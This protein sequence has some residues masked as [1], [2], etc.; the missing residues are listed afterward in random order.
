MMSD[1]PLQ[2]LY[3]LGLAV[4]ATLDLDHEAEAFM[5]W[6]AEAVRPALAALFVT[7][8]ARQTL[9]L[10]GVHG[11]DLPADPHLPL[12]MD[13]WRWLAEQGAPIPPEGDPARYAVPILVEQQLFGILCLVSR[14]RAGRLTREQRLVSTAANYL[15]PVLRNIWRYQTVEDL[16]EERTAS[17][18]ESEARYRRLAGRLE[19]L[20]EMDR[21]IIE[22][23]SPGEIARAALSRVRR[24]L[25]CQRA[26]VLL[27]DFEADE[28]MVLATH[29]NGETSVGTGVRLPLAAFDIGEKLKEGGVHVM[30]DTFALSELPPVVERLREEGIR[31][32]VSVPLIVEGRLIGALYLGT[33]RP[34]TFTDEQIEIAREVANSLAIAIQQARL[35]EEV[36][37]HARE[38]EQRVAERTR[39]LAASEAR[40]RQIVE[41]PLVGFYQTDPEGRFVF[42]NQRLVEMSGYTVEEASSKNMLDVVA[43]EQRSWLAERMSRRREG[44]FLPDVTEAE[45]VRKDGS[46][47]TALV[48]P[49][50]LY[51]G[52]G[53]FVGFI[54]AMIDISE[55]KKLERKLQERMAEVE[56]LNRTLTSLLGD[57]QAANRDLEDMATRLKEANEELEAFAYSVSHDLRAPLRAMHGFAQALLEDY[58]DL[59]DHQAQDYA[60][61]IVWAAQWMDAMIQD[62]LAY[63]RVSRV[64]MH[65]RPVGLGQAVQEALARLETEIEERGAR[66]TVEEPLPD[67]I[68]HRATLVQ[69]VENLLSNAVKFVAEGVQ[70]RVQVWAE[71]RGEHVRLWVADN[72]IGIAP[73]YHERIFRVFE[74]LYGVEDYPGTGIGL[75]IVKKG[76]ERMGG[77]VGVES[78]V[79]R[80]SRFWIEL[81]RA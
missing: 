13:L 54:G 52:E 70:P 38:L 73:E 78:D 63:S 4:G 65:L 53:N 11:F 37:R 50:G 21:A 8:R 59:L 51:D 41:S 46:R 17:L 44:G 28:G 47:F 57:L 22:A 27:F 26:S 56:Q 76:V 49:A 29:V 69:V 42:I 32:Y 7:D 14:R 10:V 80:G 23:R 64:E 24:L 18:A 39:Q 6:L 67:V 33:D 74:R 71:E 60:R 15:G 16:V 66:V 43:P 34:V 62:L 45:I 75:A 12:G 55:R 2:Q 19:I 61:R 5:G 20:R 40:Y 9:R 30:E 72:G 77:R 3:D 79:G 31:S 35:H 58:A 81:E 25:P 68:G 1:Q 48:A 36:R